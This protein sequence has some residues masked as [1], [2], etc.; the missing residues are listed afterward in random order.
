MRRAESIRNSQRRQPSGRPITNA[1]N[2]ERVEVVIIVGCLL[3]GIG[4]GMIAG[5]A[6]AGALIGLGIGFLGEGLFGRGRIPW[7]RSRSAD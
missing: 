7:G 5:N 6:G 4:V 3:V 1:S 2:I